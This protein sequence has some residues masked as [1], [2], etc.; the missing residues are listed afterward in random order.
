MAQVSPQIISNIIKERP[1]SRRT[2]V[3]IADALGIEQSY[4]LVDYLG[5]PAEEINIALFHSCQ[6]LV[7]D[8]C[9]KRNINVDKTQQLHSI[10]MDLYEY[11]DDCKGDI[12]Y[13]SSL[14]EE[15]KEKL[16]IMTEAFLRGLLHVQLK[17]GLINKVE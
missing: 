14:Y 17:L 10:T 1:C 8:I 15:K 7:V 2:L 4:F 13:T 12:L 5:T 11:V 16:S 6:K 3:K 9:K